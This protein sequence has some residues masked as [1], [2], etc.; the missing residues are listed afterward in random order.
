MS[1]SHS[2]S[3]K[4]FFRFYYELLSLSRNMENYITDKVHSLSI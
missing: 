3:S 2:V 1:E 4:S